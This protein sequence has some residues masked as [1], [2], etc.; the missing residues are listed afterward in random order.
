M[1]KRHYKGKSSAQYKQFV[2][3]CK[4][5]MTA[6]D[7]HSLCTV[8]LGAEEH[9]QSATRGRQLSAL[10]FSSNARASLPEGF[11]SISRGA[12][13]TAAEVKWRRCSWGS[14]VDLLEGMETGESLSPFHPSDSTVVLSPLCGYF[15]PRN[16]LEASLIFL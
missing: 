11:I 14:Q 13:P 16:G 1:S 12:G 15:S 6:G 5:Y 10:R 7:T 8:Y 9:A 4:Q 2:P 3:P